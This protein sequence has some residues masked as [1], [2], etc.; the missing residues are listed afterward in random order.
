[1]NGFADNAANLARYYNRVNF[2]LHDRARLNLF[3]SEMNPFQ[4]AF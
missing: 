2:T 4:V 1:M 3:V